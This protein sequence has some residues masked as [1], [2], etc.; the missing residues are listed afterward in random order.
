M[1]ICLLKNGGIL[2]YQA[3][4]L[5]LPPQKIP[6]EVQATPSRASHASGAREINSLAP[7]APWLV[8]WRGWLAVKDGTSGEPVV[9]VGLFCW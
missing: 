5:P 6:F 9:L 4:Y 7:S 3:G 1:L 2:V 8:G